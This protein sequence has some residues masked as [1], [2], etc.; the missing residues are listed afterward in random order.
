[1]S[2]PTGANS[3]ER[4]RFIGCRFGSAD[5]YIEQSNGNASTFLNCCSFNYSPRMIYLS[6]G[7]LYFTDGHIENDKDTT[8]WFYIT[9]NNTMLNIV[10]THIVVASAKT[11]YSEFYV[12]SDV[13][14][15]G[16]FI[17]N[18]HYI[19]SSIHSIPL[20]AGLS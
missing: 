12:H 11:T 6:A 18:T 16:L 1:M 17:N 2:I 7:T 9:G 20:V 8:E 5:N 3:G 4:N 14:K 19:N 10:N 15:G 13:I